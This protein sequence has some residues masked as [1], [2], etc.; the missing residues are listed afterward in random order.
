LTDFD[1]LFFSLF[2]SS[3]QLHAF[4]FCFILLRFLFLSLVCFLQFLSQLWFPSLDAFAQRNPSPEI[5]ARSQAVDQVKK[6]S[7]LRV[8]FAM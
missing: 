5:P 6:D 1:Q 7:D 3:W 8:A 2:L 4:A